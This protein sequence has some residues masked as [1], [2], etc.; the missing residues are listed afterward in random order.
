MGKQARLETTPV[1]ARLLQSFKQSPYFVA[2]DLT[3]RVPLGEIHPNLQ[4]SVVGA[5]AAPRT[6]L[7][8]I[9][10]FAALGLSAPR[11]PTAS[12]QLVSTLPVAHQ[13]PVARQLEEPALS[14]PAS[15]QMDAILPV[16]HPI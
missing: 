16:T 13:L 1:T 7:N 11:A 12:P 14:P 2:S 15:A 5:G 8:P 4:P 3:H 9:R 6:S 10:P